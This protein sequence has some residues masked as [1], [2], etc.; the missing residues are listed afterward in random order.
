[1][2]SPMSSTE[3]Y[4]RIVDLTGLG[5]DLHRAQVGAVREGEVDRV[6][7]RVGVEGGL[8]AVGQVVGR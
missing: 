5:V 1:M 7:G 6:V 4:V 2:M 3:T 8:H